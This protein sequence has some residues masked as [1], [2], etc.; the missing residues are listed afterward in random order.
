MLYSMHEYKI[1]KYIYSVYDQ[2]SGINIPDNY[3]SIY[4]Y[5]SYFNYL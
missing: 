3:V 1:D 2:V 4:I 5:S